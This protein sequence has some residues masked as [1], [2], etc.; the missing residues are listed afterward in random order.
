MDFGWGRDM[1]ASTLLVDAAVQ[2]VLPNL[3][4]GTTYGVRRMDPTVFPIISYALTSDTLS[5]VALRD[6]AQFQ[7][8]PLLSAVPGLARV[9]VQGGETAE[10]QVL[11]DPHR[12]AAYGIGLADLARR[13][14]RR[15]RAAVGRDRCRTAS[16]LF[17]VLADHSLHT[18]AEIGDVV[19]RG[20]RGRRGA[21]ARCGDRAARRGAAMDRRRGGRQ[22]GRAVQRL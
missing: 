20:D 8:V 17:L 19:V 13:I 12:L 10:I 4:A 21:R 3:P 6:F 18:A 1:V 7:I 14:C 11:A 9:D 15:Q 5:P 16:K 22:A 2:Q